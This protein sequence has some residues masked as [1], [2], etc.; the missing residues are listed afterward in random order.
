[1]NAHQKQVFLM[2]VPVT[3]IKNHRFRNRFGCYGGTRC[4]V[5]APDIAD[6]RTVSSKLVPQSAAICATASHQFKSCNAA[7]HFWLQALNAILQAELDRVSQTLTRRIRELA[8]RYATPLPALADEV[9][10]LSAKVGE[11]L[12]RMGVVWK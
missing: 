11:H 4:H 1:M 5:G 7:L 12:K 9:E 10:A 2:F 8:E 6:A 3:R